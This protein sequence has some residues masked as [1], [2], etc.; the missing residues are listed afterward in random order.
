MDYNFPGSFVHGI[1]QARL[2]EWVGDLLHPGIKSGSPA[3]RFF[4]VWATKDAQWRGRGL[5]DSLF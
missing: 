4:T 2:V 1:L 5:I 3:G